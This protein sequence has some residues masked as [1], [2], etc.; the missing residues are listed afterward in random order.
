MAIRVNNLGSVL[1]E[2]GELAGARAACERALAIPERVY[3]PDHP[4]VAT[5]VNS[6][7][8]VLQ[9]LGELAGAR[10]AFERVL[11]IL[12]RLLPPEHPSIQTV[13]RNLKTLGPLPGSKSG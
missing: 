12:E 9:D 6:L 4:T 8:C 11:A 10:V 7:G 13:R 3:G 5:D 2:L 1:Q